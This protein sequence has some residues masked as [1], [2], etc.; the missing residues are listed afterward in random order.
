MLRTLGIQSEHLEDKLKRELLSLI[1]R[2][3]RANLLRKEQKI[4]L[5]SSK[6]Q[7]K[8]HSKGS[9]LDAI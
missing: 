1:Q 7:N 5:P 4:T 2:S 6:K 8:K 9:Y 3:Q